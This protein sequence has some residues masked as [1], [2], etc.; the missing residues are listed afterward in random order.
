MLKLQQYH[1]S[2]KYKKGKEMYIADTL[3]RAALTNPTKMGTSDEEV[4]RMELSSMDL[5]PPNLSNVT[6]ER[7][8]EEVSSDVT[9]KS[10]YETVLKGWPLD[11]ALLPVDLRPYWSFR[12]EITV[13]KGILLKS[14]QVIIP[15][16]MRQEMLNKIHKAHQGADSSIRRARET[17]FW[18]GMSAA[19]RQTCSSCGLCAQ[20]KSER[21]TEP[22]KSQEIPTLPWERVR[23]DLFQLDG[24]TY[25]VTVDHYSDFIE[26]DWLKN[27]SAMAVINAMKKNFTRAGIPRVCIS[28]NGPQFSSHEYSQFASEYGFNPVK[29]SPYHSKGNGK[30]ESAVKVAKNILKK[31]RHEDPYLALLAYRNTPQQ[32]HKFSPAQR[33]MNQKLRDITVSVPQQLIPHPVPSTEV[34]NDIMSRRVRSKQQYDKR[35]SPHPLNTFL[36]NDRVFVKPNPKN[37]HKPWIYGEVVKDCGHRSC[38]VDTSLGLIQ[39]NHKQIRKAEVTPQSFNK[40]NQEDVEIISLPDETLPSLTSLTSLTPLTIETTEKQITAQPPPP[41]ETQ[42]G[43]LRRSTRIRK[44]PVKLKD[45]VR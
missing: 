27:T 41:E 12:D 32:G 30:A 5:R 34:V 1:F 37:K 3:S 15:S 28:D 45:Y 36:R 31:A 33:L 23:V 42:P 13:D 44:S 22:M 35:A 6:F 26:I 7:L 8:K 17:L 21:P 40:A 18:P 43:P 25:L 14:H 39:R 24:K 38:V 10:L 29:S 11:R 19:I 20:Y 9:M 16:S 4:F 2:V